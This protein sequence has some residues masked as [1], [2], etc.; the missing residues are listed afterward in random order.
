MLDSCDTGRI[1][2]T[3]EEAQLPLENACAVSESVPPEI[4]PPVE[5]EEDAMP[6][7][8]TPRPILKDQHMNTETT[9]IPKAK[10]AQSL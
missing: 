9:D 10:V 2:R 1:F 5:K 3:V 8:R 4:T 6:A 7:E